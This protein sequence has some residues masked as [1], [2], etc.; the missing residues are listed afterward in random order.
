MIPLERKEKIFRLIKNNNICTVEELSKKFN[1][2]KVTIHRVLNELEKE[3]FVMKIHGGAKLLNKLPLMERFDIRLRVNLKKKQEIAKKAVAFVK[4]GD[5][6]FIDGSTSCFVFVKELSKHSYSNLTVVTN[7]PFVVC[8]LS[9]F[10]NIHVISTGGE[11][12]YRLDAL[13]GSMTINFISSLHLSKAFVCV[14][15]ISLERGLMTSQLV[16]LEVLQKVFEIV[17]EINV[18]MD[19]SKFSSQAMLT[20]IPAT[21]VNCVISD[22]KLPKEIINQYEKLGVRIVV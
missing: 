20:I 13:G 21:Q 18:L 6:I 10:P 15:G 16:V 1:V 4:E 19:S 2:S 8:E 17:D 14:S 7:S 9:K 5:S 22:S 3:G 11:L 12:Q